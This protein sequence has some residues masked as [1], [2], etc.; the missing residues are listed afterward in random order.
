[1]RARIGGAVLAADELTHNRD[2]Q[3]VGG[4]WRVRG[5]ASSAVLKLATPRG[6]GAAPWLTSD[7]PRHWNYWPSIRESETPSQWPVA[8]TALSLSATSPWARS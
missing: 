2:N 1:M 3:A 5:P 6:E 7:D 8:G 4:V